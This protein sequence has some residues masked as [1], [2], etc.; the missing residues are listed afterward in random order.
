MNVK[1]CVIAGAGEYS[2]KIP[3][4]LE[5]DYII[6]ADGGYSL[7]TARGLRADALI[8]DFDSLAS[9]PEHG[10]IIRLSVEKDDTDMLAAIRHGLWKGY[11]VFHIYGGTGG[12]LSH[13]LANIECLAYLSCI[14]AR[15]FLFGDGFY[16]TAVTDGAL[17][18]DAGQSGGISVFSHGDSSQG[19]FLD[20]LKYSLD[21]A[22]LTNTFPLGVSNSF[23]GQKSSVRVEKGT[24][25]VICEEKNA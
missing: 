23:T 4:P 25:I 10:N 15:A 8:G 17:E 11:R 16:I 19:V 7:L 18:F 13:T 21:N 9:P 12:R 2:G 5:D 6:A 14:G 24:L 3:D 20:G 1:K 22:V